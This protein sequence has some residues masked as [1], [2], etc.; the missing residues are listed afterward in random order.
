MRQ[1]FRMLFRDR[2]FTLAAIVLLAIGI[3][4][5]TAIFTLIDRLLLEPMPYPDSQSLV[6]IWSIPPRAG[7]GQ[8]GLLGA[9]FREIRDRNHA[10]ESV[11]GFIPGAWIFRGPNE[12]ETLPGGRVSEGF[13]ETLGVHP[14]LGRFFYP[15]EHR[16]GFEME[17]I[18][19]YQFW[20]QRYG[21][22]PGVIGRHISLDGIPYEVVG[23]M[24]QDFPFAAE[25]DIWAPMQDLTIAPNSR[26]YHVVRTIARVKK[27]ID[28]KRAQAEGNAL[29]ADLADRFP[30]DKGYSLKTESLLDH[31]V[32]SVRR[33]LW[34]FGGAV[35]CILLI[36]CS[37]V[38]SLLLA[39]GAGRVREMAVR[40][41]VGASRTVLVRQ[42]LIES[43]LLAVFGGI[44]GFPLA[45]LGVRLLIALSPHALPRANEVRIDTGVL[46][47]AFLVSLATGMIFGVFPALR[48]SRVN[49]ATALKEGGRSGTAGRDRNHFRAA[50]VVVEVALGVVLMAAAGLLTRS[51]QAL[52]HVDPGYRVGNVLTMR[53]VLTGATYLNLD[54]CRRFF[55]RLLP[56]LEQS[57][58]IEAAGTT[59]WLPLRPDKN[60]AGIWLDTQPVRSEDTKIRLD[61]RIVSP[62]YFRALG[63]PL[64]A[65]RFF[66]QTDRPGNPPVV[67]VNDAFAREFFP[68]GDALGHRVI[69][70]FGTLLNAEIVGV[71]GGTR[72]TS[73]AENP[74]RE[75]FTPYAQ[76]TIPG[77]SLVVRTTGDPAAYAAAV[78]GAV[79]SIDRNIP[80]YDTRTMQAQVD[81]SLAQPRLRGVLLSVFSA[82]ALVLASLGIY[83]VIACA[84]AERRQEIG[85]RMAL[86]AR[87]NQVR[88]MVVNAGLKLTILGLAIGL[89][90]AAATTHLL[91]G[92]LFGVTPG[93]P[94]TFLAT[95][96]IFVLVA[97]AA[98]YL[99]ARRATRVDPLTVLRQE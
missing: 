14:L 78:R 69:L 20:H 6:W 98:S 67:I 79:A 39:R 88:L 54:E 56:A 97:F 65:G 71:V 86:G 26:R 48:A 68:R 74:R 45:V 52:T 17:V 25:H 7:A 57:P 43:G 76:T 60:T 81:Q 29:A 61:N 44:L 10:F 36:A 34:I 95:A 77:Q 50:L 66:E 51:L 64:I 85:I 3:G 73:L 24:P 38:A 12:S 8:T 99:P 41:A 82:I 30:D 37:N 80:V 9:D 21:G 5:T 35:G 40:A 89:A 90:G 62:G 55:D 11:A 63:V 91:A 92:F 46:V 1:A 4:T 96:A 19:S 70:D 47:F 27:G 2:G 18:F 75:L 53:I 42:L 84:V 31:E 13:F 94:F 33:S 87:S 23:I 22:D 15:D 83:G 59:N 93:D 72:E 16:K 28:P 32:G 49:V 58:G